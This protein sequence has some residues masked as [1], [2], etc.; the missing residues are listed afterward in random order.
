M[1]GLSNAQQS[2]PGN[3]HVRGPLYRGGNTSSYTNKYHYLELPVI[4]HA[5][6]NRKPRFPFCL[7]GGVSLSRLIGSNALHFDNSAQ[8]YFNDNSLLN[9]TGFTLLTGMSMRFLTKSPFQIEAGPQIQYGL[10][11]LFKK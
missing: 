1:E 5:Q 6:L 2:L 4:F 8:L 3:Q 9:K 10:N 7:N 11:K